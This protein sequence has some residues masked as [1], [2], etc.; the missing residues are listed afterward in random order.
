MDSEDLRPCCIVEDSGLCD[1]A[2]A[3]FPGHRLPSLTHVQELLK[4]LGYEKYKAT[5]ETLVLSQTGLAFTI[6]LW[7]RASFCVATMCRGRWSHAH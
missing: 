2:K 3:L 6:D 1:F 5:L 4:R 7:T